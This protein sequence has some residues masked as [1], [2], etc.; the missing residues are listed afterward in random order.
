MDERTTGDCV[1]WKLGGS[2]LRR[3]ADY[4]LCAARLAAAIADRATLRIVAVVSA[5]FGLTNR[6]VRQAQRVLGDSSTPEVDLLLATG[7]LQSV[8]QLTMR[9][10]R[11]GVNCVGLTPD[12]IGLRIDDENEHG[13]SVDAT[14]VNRRLADHR[15]IVVPGFVGTRAGGGWGT[16]GRGGSDLTAVALAAALDARRCELI[17]DVPGYFTSDPNVDASAAHLEHV[18]YVRALEMAAAGCDLVQTEALRH[19]EQWG[20]E[21]IVRKL[22]GDRRCTTVRERVSAP[23]GLVKPARSGDSMYGT[24]DGLAAAAP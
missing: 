5:R 14:F 20:L 21:L 8:A 2:I 22:D 10:R 9:L 11:A 17:K 6:L 1:V 16:L 3:S 24:A 15:V 23:A 12:E 18:S 13:F 19:A 7:E 4:D